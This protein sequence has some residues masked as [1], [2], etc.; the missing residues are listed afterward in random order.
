MAEIPNPLRAGLAGWL[1][2]MRAALV[3]GLAA[4]AALGV[5]SYLEARDARVQL[6]ATLAA[7]KNVI[8]QADARERERAGELRDALA[9]IE[10]LKRRVQTPQQIVREI[11]SALPPLPQPI[12]LRLPEPKPNEP[13]PP[14]TAIIPQPDLKPIFDAIQDCRACQLQLRAAQNDLTDERAKIVALTT[15]RD[16]AIRAAR[17]G[18]FW[19]RVRRGAKWL[20]IGV[21]VGA[22][23]AAVA[24]HR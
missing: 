18:G 2:P 19:T 8:A 21:A 24:R 13:A 11:P 5:R 12:E 1:A 3:L 16:A 22:G 17:G 4:T 6:V 14:A 10:S 20:A 9:Q 23:A 15:E 7:Q